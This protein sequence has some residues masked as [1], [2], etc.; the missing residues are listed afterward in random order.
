MI[1][2]R[3]DFVLPIR[4]DSTL[5]E[6][7]RLAFGVNIPDKPICKNHQTP[8]AAFADAYFARSPISIWKASRSLGGKTFLL[9]LLSLTEALT[10]KCDVSLIGGSGEQS[11]RAL[12]AMQ[13]FT[14]YQ[15][16]PRHL[17]RSEILRETKFA[18]GNQVEALMASQASVRGP[19]PARLR[20][21]EVD[22]M[23][24]AIL[25]S[26]LGQPM[27]QGDVL[28]QVVQSSTHQYADGTMAEVL[29]RAGEN[30]HSVFEWCY[31]E[32]LQP[33][34]WLTEIEMLRKKSQM[35]KLSWE[36]EVELQE[37]N[38]QSRAIDTSAVKKMFKP[39]LGEYD[40]FEHQAIEI[41]QPVS[42]ATYATGIDWAKEQD[43]TV[44]VTL[45]TDVK[46]FRMVAFLMTYRELWPVM[47]GYGVERAKKYPGGLCH[48]GTGLGD[49]VDDIVQEG[50]RGMN[51]VAIWMGGID[52]AKL[53][54]DY[55]VEIERGG[56]ESPMIKSM[57]TQHLRASK[58]DVFEGGH[59]HHLPDTISAG[60]LALRA[61]GQTIEGRLMV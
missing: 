23:D 37:P 11:K 14:A 47:I 29:K 1:T 9:S 4:N 52:R 25:D 41:E 32:T 48:D 28:S 27:S 8:F 49:V 33:H 5:K 38:P 42:G 20:C 36:N 51:A 3:H 39:E 59:K 19:H 58:A 30:G 15:N 7:V 6:F 57:Y 40:G 45:R 17:L 10:L 55:I 61:A 24:L 56:I 43:R 60:A 54:S 12:E 26:A 31:K 21:D 34:G 50:M 46:P 16:A 35:T 2:A 13:K 44:I 18:W 22:E 53:L